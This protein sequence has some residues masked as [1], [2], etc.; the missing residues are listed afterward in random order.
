MERVGGFLGHWESMRELRN[1][2][3]LN[4]SQSQI[5]N[6]YIRSLLDTLLQILI[7]LSDELGI[8]RTLYIDRNANAVTSTISNKCRHH[9]FAHCSL[10]T[11]FNS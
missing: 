7:Q 2:I 9:H 11:F 5:L 3:E 8:G 10:I 6:I 4:T 1:L